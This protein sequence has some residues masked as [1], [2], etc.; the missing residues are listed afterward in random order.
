MSLD[1]S[2]VMKDVLRDLAD[3]HQGS[4]T[5][6]DLL[7][8]VELRSGQTGSSEATDC[9]EQISGLLREEVQADYLRSASILSGVIEALRGNEPEVLLNDARKLPE[10]VRSNLESVS[11]IQQLNQDLADRIVETVDRIDHL[12]G[13]TAGE[14]A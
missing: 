2:E 7:L 1:C 12:G 3:T 11:N 9:R 14:H 5:L 4:I 8:Q 13:R 10:L 6:E